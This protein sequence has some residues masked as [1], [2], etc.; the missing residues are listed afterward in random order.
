[1]LIVNLFLSFSAAVTAILGLF[2]IV[3]NP[4][5]PVNRALLAF[6]TG[7]FLWLLANLLTNLSGNPSVSLFFART[8]LIGVC[9]MMATF[10]VFAKIY[11]K[12]SHFGRKDVLKIAAAPALIAVLFPTSL[13]IV[14]IKAFGAE[15]VTGPIYFPL[16][17]LLVAYFIW[18][19]TVLGRYYK[20]SRD[21]MERTRLRYIF[22][23]F[24]LAVIPGVV[25]NSVLPALG[26]NQAILYGPN[27]VLFIV[28]FMTVGIVKHRLLDVRLIVARSIAYVLLIS[29][30]I[31]FYGVFVFVFASRIF[32]SNAFSQQVVPV[33]V[34]IFLA[35]TIQ[36]LRKYFDRVSNQFFYRDAYD[37]QVFL[38]ELNNVLVSNIELKKLATES[39]AVM[40]KNLKSDYIALWTRETEDSPRRVISDSPRKIGD[41]AIATIDKLTEGIQEKVLVTDYLDDKAL[42]LK[43]ILTSSDVAILIRLDSSVEQ[44]TRGLGYLLLGAKKS[45]NPY[46]TQDIQVLEIIANEL[47]ITVQNALRFEEIENFNATLQQKVDD[48]T[49]K[50]QRANEKLTALDETKDEFISMASH[51]LRTPLTSVKGYVSM[52]LE[53]DAGE[54]QPMQKKL[55]E[56]SFASSQ[57]MVYLIADLLNLSRL[58]TGKFVIETKPTNLADVIESEVEQLKAS[59]AGRGLT[60]DFKKPKTFTPLM[61]DEVKIRQVIMNFSDNAIYYTPA[62]GKIDIS[63]KETKDSVEFTVNDNGIGVPALEQRHLFTKFYRAKNAQKARPDGTGLGLFMAKKVIIAQGGALV[64]KSVH[65]KGSTFGFTFSKAK[66][67]VPADLANPEAKV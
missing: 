50:L 30:I 29:S 10:V 35:F 7:L 4:R 67:K 36:P 28:V 42:A 43:K 24:G 11:T 16:S 54:L 48:A 1:M 59:A 23:G 22:A 65:D 19:F 32:G 39:M 14:S 56:Q 62:G 55:L 9:L 41:N 21:S 20:H 17:I 3:S 44:R 33:F 61:L 26:H 53:G 64:F 31:G 66:L 38:D 51:Q 45:G 25:T 5:K 47:V 13:N 34:S 12:Q 8:T 40:G 63:L 2:I 52:V 46:N 37:S 49:R 57:R 60:L 27:S 58:R 18:G 6:F 15:T